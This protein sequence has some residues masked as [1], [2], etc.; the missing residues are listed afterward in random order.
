MCIYSIFFRSKIC[1]DLFCRIREQVDYDPGHFRNSY[2]LQLVINRFIRFYNKWLFFD[3]ALNT[4]LTISI[5]L[6]LT[7]TLEF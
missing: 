6:I 7:P 4:A 1:N 5:C 3:I 2:H